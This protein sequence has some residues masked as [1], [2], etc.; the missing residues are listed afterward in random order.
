M[1]PPTDG[2]TL[3]DGMIRSLLSLALFGGLLAALVWV[4]QGWQRAAESVAPG[5][6]PLVVYYASRDADRLVGERY[7]VEAGGSTPGRAVELL[8]KGPA[9]PALV[10]PLPRGTRVLEVQVRGGE[11][12]V[13]FSEDILR[14]HEGGTAGEVMTVYALVNTLT[15]LEGIHRVGI[16]VEGRPVESLVGHLDLA[17]PL[18]RD[19]TLIDRVIVPPW[20][21]EA[22]EGRPGGA[23]PGWPWWPAVP[24]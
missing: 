6:R 13:N 24:L 17:E 4:G 1:N 21:G 20:Q 2:R 19:E 12:W 7:W 14:L 3:P 22:G 5:R 8:L 16:L 11:A 15:E 18:A 23:H 10:S 9:S